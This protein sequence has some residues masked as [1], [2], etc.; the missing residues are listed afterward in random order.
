MKD[1][2]KD[3]ITLDNVVWEEE[4]RRLRMVELSTQYHPVFSRLVLTLSCFFVR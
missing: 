4:I 1:I 3:W 2:R